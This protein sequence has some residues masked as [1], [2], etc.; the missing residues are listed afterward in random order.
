MTAWRRLVFA[1]PECDRDDLIVRLH[2]AGTL[3][4]ETAPDGVVAWFPGAAELDLD[5]AA[6][7]ARLVS[8]ETVSDGLW[9]ERWVARLAPFPVGERFLIVPGPRAA[10]DAAGRLTL[11][12]TP[13]R[14]FGTGEHPTT[15]LCLAMLERG[16]RPGDR[17]L[18]AGT[19]SGIL[20]IA[21]AK[22]GAALVIGVDIDAEA[23]SIAQRNALINDA[24]NDARPIHFVAG[25]LDA[26]SRGRFDLVVANITGVALIRMMP[27]L[28]AL[29][30]REAILS[31]LLA[32]EEPEVVDAAARAGLRRA[33]G[34]TRDGWA[35]LALSR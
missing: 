9:H 18:D 17:V 34:E 23:V 12:L 1:V 28:A 24:V 15:Q 29:A 22:L 2:E 16:S 26:V 6:G 8:A 19:G 21:A 3:G 20:A 32:S 7:S 13:G 27:A 14:A 33:D 10:P 25:S 30:G 5:R 31:G 11:R 35:A 4:V